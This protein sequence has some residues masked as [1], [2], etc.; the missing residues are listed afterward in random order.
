M[1][2]EISFMP[3]RVDVG[4]F[5]VVLAGAVASSHFRI[6]SATYVICGCQ[7]AVGPPNLTIRILEAL[8]R[9][10]HSALVPSCLL[11]R[12]KAKSLEVHTGE[13]TSCTRCRSVRHQ[14]CQSSFTSNQ[15]R[16]HEMGREQ[17]DIQQQRAVKL[18][19]H[20]VG[21]KNLVVERLRGTLGRRH[22]VVY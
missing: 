13:V 12:R 3:F 7:R 4:T 10:L 14:I 18:L 20:D 2:L 21:L 1:K 5:Y 6:M 22:F 16:S 15:S 17:T 9:L 19:V 11:S 8:E